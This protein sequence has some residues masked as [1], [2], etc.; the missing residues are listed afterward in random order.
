MESQD[1]TIYCGRFNGQ[2]YR[3][4]YYQGNFYY[5]LFLKGK[6]RDRVKNLVRSGGGIWPEKIKEDRAH[7]DY[8]TKLQLFDEQM[9]ASDE[10]ENSYQQT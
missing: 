6:E 9:E 7:P 3:L 1:I 10:T 2:F 8:K 5:P 4:Y